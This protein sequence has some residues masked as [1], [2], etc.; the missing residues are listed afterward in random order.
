MRVENKSM[1]SKPIGMAEIRLFDHSDRAALIDL[2]ETVF[3][4]ATDHNAP[5]KVIDEKLRF[6]GMIFVAEVDNRIIG[7]CIAGYDGHRGWLYAVAV[8]PTNRRSGVGK[9]LVLHAIDALRQVGCAKLNLQIRADNIAVA[10]FYR[11]IGFD[12]EERMSMGMHL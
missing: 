3:P 10:E 11:S 6:D 8:S 4:D 5:E 12:V 7:S 2:W 9:Q 1:W